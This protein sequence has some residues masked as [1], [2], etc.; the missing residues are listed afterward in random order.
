MSS[1]SG[2]S[3][4]G[5]DNEDIEADESTRND[6][7]RLAGEQEDDDDDVESQE[8]YEDAEEEVHQQ[9]GVGED[10]VDEEEW[11]DGELLPDGEF[12]P[13]EDYAQLDREEA[14]TPDEALPDEAPVTPGAAS[15][16]ASPPYSASNPDDT[17][18][19]AGSLLSSPGRG[20][21]PL[22]RKAVNRS[23]S[24]ALQPFERRFEARPSA[25]RSPSSRAG[26]P[27]FLSPHSRQVS[28]SSQFSQISSQG[29]SEDT[30]TPQAPWDVV[31]WTKLRKIAGQAFSEAGKRNF[32]RPTC[33]A[34]SALIAIGTSRG[35][36]LGFD[37]HQ[38]LKIIIGQG[39]K[40]TECGSVTALAIAADYSTIAAGH[41]NGHIFTWE[42]NRPSQPF[43]R[44][45]PIPRSALQQSKHADG[46]LEGTA[47]LHI[48]FL[49]TRHT[50]IVSADAGGMAFSHLA[51]R[52]LGPVTR[53]IKTTRLLG[54]YPPADPTAE[55]SRK[56]SS[57]LAFSP[58][59]LG[60]VEQPT[61]NM[62]LTALLTP[63]LLVIVSTT[64]I[65]QTQFKSPRPKEMSPHSA[66]SGCLAWFPAVKLKTGSNG[67]DRGTS[68]TKLVYCWSNMLTV[69]DV[70][71][72]PREEGADE[73]KPPSLE[74]HPRSRWRADE[75][76]VGVQWLGRSILGVLTISQRLLIVED[77]SLRVTD[78]MD[79]LHRHIYHQDLYSAQLQSVVE[80][81]NS[82]DPSLHGVV[83]DAFY[84]SFRAYKGRLFLLGFNDLTVGTLSNWADRLMAL[85]EAG[86]HVAAIRLATEYYVGGANNVTVG[87]PDD[88]LARHRIVRER[89]IAMISASLNYTFSQHDDGRE[90]RLRE[91]ATVCFDACISMSETEYLFGDI[92]EM[93]ED[94]E[95]EDM[96]ISTLEPYVLDGD[97]KSVPPEV[98]KTM[99]SHFIS[100]NQATRL[101]ELLCRLDPHSF[102]L[103]EVSMLC[104]Q[105]SLFDAL[106]YIWTQALG[107]FVTPLIDLLTLVKML[108]EGDEDE[109]WTD[110]PFYES[111]VKIFPYVA[112]SLTSRRYPSGVLMDEN[113]ASHA[114]TDLYEYLFS[115]RP[116]AWPP[117]SKRVFRTTDS[118]Q[119]EPAFPYLVLLL[120]FDAA[121]FMSMLNEAFEDPF[122]NGPEDEAGT[123]GA[124]QANGITSRLG[125]K[126][127][128]QH[129][130][131]IM[132]D[133]MKQ[134]GFEP[135]QTIYLDMFIAR[136]LP[137]YPGQLVV[138]GSL[139]DGVL[140]RLC[141]PP[142]QA[143]R[144]ECQ[145]SVEYL[146]SA[147]HP[148]DVSSLIEALR[149]A[150]FYRV[151]KSVY[152]GARMFTELLE[153]YFTDPSDK[154]AVFDCI[155]YCLRPS[156][157][158]NQ[159]QL[160]SVKEVI[161][162]HVLELVDISTIL[163]A[164]TLALHA[165]D[166]L[167]PSINTVEDSYVQFTF[168][169]TLLEPALLRDEG[170]SQMSP[171]PQGEQSAFT[172]QY[173]QLMCKH[174]PTHVA[175]Y[176]G[177]L[178]TSDLRLDQVLPA[179][180]ASGVVDAAVVLLA[181]DGLARDA[182]DRLVAHLQRLQQALGD[183]IEATGQS[184]DPVAAQETAQELVEDIEK[185][186]KVGI[187]LC[188]GQSANAQRK[189][190]P[191]Q[192]TVLDVSEDD[193]DLDEYLWLNLVDTV[194]QISKNIG[195]ALQH[196]NEHPSEAAADVVDT[197]KLSSSL[198]ANV[199]QTFTALLGATATPSVQSTQQ[200]HA[201]PPPRQRD[202]HLS[203]LRILRAFLTRAS[204]TA[205]SLADLRS[206]LADI[207]SAYT[208]EQSVLTLANDLLGS[209][210]FTDIADAHARRQ[211]GWRPRTQ[212]CDKCKRRAWGPGI[213]EAV[214]EAWVQREG[215]REAEKARKLV[216]RGGGEE[217]RRLER[218]KAKA[219]TKE[220]GRAGEAASGEEKKLALVVFA[221]RHVFHRVCLDEEFRDGRPLRQE[222]YR[223]PLCIEHA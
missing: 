204:R 79:L 110:N 140:R 25:S 165:K 191:R 83:A 164:R 1:S 217:A 122:L 16:L 138:S 41:A 47:I 84:M 97:V 10:G 98:V 77:G 55:R 94:A 135:E 116:T 23:A 27:A 73:N 145:L 214:W 195:E 173:T 176:V 19:Q 188:Q 82:L 170:L 221:C 141:Q 3:H 162:A 130:V 18:S 190:R 211:R 17:P 187:W 186:T 89:L 75:A 184:P 161:M 109:D 163:T 185:Y 58:L 202:E 92:F 172:E 24:A 193:L 106:I 215:E 14:G 181:R 59:P 81:L 71:I 22:S 72:V 209:D 194:V 11:R 128:R 13:A 43:L 113:E 42:I 156:T 175:D 104:R 139:L 45:P 20:A 66:L 152:R 65:A 153:T 129:I 7:G 111:A 167:Q 34:V 124:S 5:G 210:V 46:H 125:Y 100:E 137:K 159:K 118:A 74:F 56:P 12:L 182:V 48:G 146:L 168:L 57:V 93:F 200:P 179:M 69:L 201:Q 127:T 218:G 87:L 9:A 115:G 126:M 192:A 222:R 15:P 178:P 166:L 123:N 112:Y 4:N 105:H 44:I 180:E 206:V 151:L 169:R 6:N 21:S 52:G 31:R 219:K 32:G 203:F 61:D 114:K 78:S 132:R 119:Q 154:D 103:D 33:C 76:I 205:P 120:Q 183:L 155:A 30:D 212:V 53:T 91:L 147:Y 220:G 95:E 101:E 174:D 197:S 40:A 189:P 29:G 150:R 136:S 177:M 133:V 90:T 36:V 99:V 51:S 88:E 158:L 171:L 131:S 35:L 85:M 70:K 143:L 216:E 26:S 102:D 208:F 64:P 62:G 2:G 199:Q 38:T 50:A 148:P 39:T 117:G 160:Q 28:I 198:R 149:E 157:A 67:T 213:G 86:D 54:R 68:D 196:L 144:E 142:T 207:F 60:N 134:D 80:Q 49:G 63:Y 107:D 108:Q 37:Y 8:Q 96:F 223:C 121:S